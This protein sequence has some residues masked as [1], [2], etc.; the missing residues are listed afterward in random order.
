M[1]SIHSPLHGIN[2]LFGQNIIGHLS[3]Y[4]Q[5]SGMLDMR[6]H[7]LCRISDVAESNIREEEDLGFDPYAPSPHDDGLST[8]EL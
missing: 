6:N 1:P 8:V 7:P 3:R 2:I 5:I 4:G